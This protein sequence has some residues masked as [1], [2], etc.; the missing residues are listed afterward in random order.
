MSV[1]RS[2][3][4]DTS[5]RVVLTYKKSTHYRFTVTC[6]DTRLRVNQIAKNYKMADLRSL[7]LDTSWVRGKAV[8]N[9]QMG[10]LRSLV[11]FIQVTEFNTPI[12][13]RVKNSQ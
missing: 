1:L 5:A 10:D 4:L 3:C 13:R 9:S 8:T 2:L 12:I 7:C 11:F 6:L